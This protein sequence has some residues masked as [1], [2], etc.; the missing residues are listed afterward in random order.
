METDRTLLIYCY[1][2]SLGGKYTHGER[3][4]GEVEDAFKLLDKLVEYHKD[5]DVIEIK[6]TDTSDFLSLHWKEKEGL[7]YPSGK[8]FE[9]LQKKFPPRA[10]KNQKE[11]PLDTEPKVKCQNCGTVKNRK[12]AHSTMFCTREC[13]KKARAFLSEG[14]G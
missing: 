5:P 11:I 7:L 4:S 13:E 14:F 2:K 12:D 9:R 6:V 8:G 3:I 1:R 10:V